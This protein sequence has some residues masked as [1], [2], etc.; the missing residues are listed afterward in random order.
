MIKLNELWVEMVINK[1]ILIALSVNMEA[2]IS[3]FKIWY[4]VRT[5]RKGSGK[6]Q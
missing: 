5:L 3:V 2:E 6:E 1:N 4:V